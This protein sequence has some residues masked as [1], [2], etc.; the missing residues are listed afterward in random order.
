MTF[1]T[2]NAFGFICGFTFSSVSLIKLDMP[3]L[4][5][6][7]NR[8]VMSSSYWPCPSART[9]KADGFLRPLGAKKEQSGGESVAES[10][11]P[12][13]SWDSAAIATAPLDRHCGNWKSHRQMKNTGYMT[14][15]VPPR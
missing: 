5:V 4:D 12:G 1:P 2:V 11:S 7:M 13:W 14:G 15:W 8:T 6:Y 10:S 3:E 9:L